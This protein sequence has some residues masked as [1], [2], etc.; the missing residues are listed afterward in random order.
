MAGCTW[1][2]RIG[3]PNAVTVWSWWATLPLALVASAYGG[4]LAGLPLVPWIVCAFAV[5][6]FLIVPLV[7]V[8][9]TCLSSRPRPSRPALAVLTFATLG[10]LRSQL[11]VGVAA[12]MGYFDVATI[13][14]EWP[15]MGA[16]AR[17]FSLSIIA[18]VVD[19]VRCVRFGIPGFS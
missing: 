4:A 10:A 2:W 3:G 11:M 15:L 16:I 8:R 1:W 9:A 14:W 5:N 7:I 6:L 19:S 17:A 18:V 12:A 13:L